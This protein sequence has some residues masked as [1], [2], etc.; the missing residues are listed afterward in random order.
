MKKKDINKTP[1]STDKQS[2]TVSKS[3]QFAFGKENYKLLLIGLVLIAVGFLLMIGGG[4]DDPKVFSDE[5]FNFRRLTLAPL[6]ILAGY[7]VEIFAIMKK[8]KSQ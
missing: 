2:S 5:I 3:S 8:P 4:S 6:L 1:D 7:V